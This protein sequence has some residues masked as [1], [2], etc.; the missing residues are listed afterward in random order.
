MERTR[1]HVEPYDEDTD[2]IYVQ[3]DPHGEPYMVAELFFNGA[4]WQFIPYTL[5]GEIA[6]GAGFQW[7]DPD[8]ERWAHLR[9]INNE[10]A[11]GADQ[12]PL[13]VNQGLDAALT[14]LRL[15]FRDETREDARLIAQGK[16]RIWWRVFATDL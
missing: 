13:A 12:R 10:N 1:A 6:H 5:D 8:R 14:K 11:K 16:A 2:R 9:D 4:E 3:S 15:Q 7:V